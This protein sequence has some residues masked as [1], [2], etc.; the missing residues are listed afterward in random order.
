LGAV[1]QLHF[2]QKSNLSVT[3]QLPTLCMRPSVAI[4]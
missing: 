3:L 4:A 1:A 2:I